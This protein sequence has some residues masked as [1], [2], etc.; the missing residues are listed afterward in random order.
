MLE[1]APPVFKPDVYTDAGKWMDGWETRRRRDDGY[2]WCVIALA[3]PGVIRGVNV[4][5]SHFRGNQPEACTIEACLGE[6]APDE[7]DRRGR[8]ILERVRLAPDAVNLFP[9]D[10]EGCVVAPASEHLPRRRRRPPARVRRA[11]GAN[12]Q[13]C[14]P[15]GQAV[16]LL[17]AVHG[18]R[19]VS[20]SDQCFGVPANLLQPGRGKNMGDG[21]ETRRRR[22]PGHDWCVLQLGCRGVIDSIE[23]DTAH[24]RGNYPDRCSIEIADVADGADP[25]HAT[26][27]TILEEARLQPDH[28]HRFDVAVDAPVTHARLC[29]YPDGGVSRLRLHGR[30]A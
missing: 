15:N 4:D 29:I 26:W 20:C 25:E 16:D 3:A 5:T 28:L 14:A 12:G 11:A 6:H 19:V 2:D 23:V 27:T 24:F 7:D 17:A 30:P 10:S 8:L 9:I 18:G 13:A 1:A 21:W 22:G